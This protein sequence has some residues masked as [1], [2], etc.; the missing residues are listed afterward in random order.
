MRLALMLFWLAFAAHG[1][2][3]D[4]GFAA[5][6]AGDYATALREWKPLA[7][8]GDATAQF[9]LGA[10]YANGEGVPQDYKEAVRLYRLAADQG[11]AVAQSNLGV[12]YDNGYGVPE[13]APTAYMWINIA[14]AS[15]N[16]VA[17]EN[18]DKLTQRMTPSQIEKGQDLTRACVAKNYKGC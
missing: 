1:A 9:N 17:T 2:D 11:N 16:K 8:Q 6:S 14:A 5:W 7:E 12:M 4:K 3:F 18:R 13:D 10:M 15:G